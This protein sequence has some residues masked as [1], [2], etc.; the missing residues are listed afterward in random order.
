MKSTI[1]EIK[2]TNIHDD[3]R[4]IHSLSQILGCYDERLL[5]YRDGKNANE[6]NDSGVKAHRTKTPARLK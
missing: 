4:I 2:A 5:S 3:T 1:T 6:I